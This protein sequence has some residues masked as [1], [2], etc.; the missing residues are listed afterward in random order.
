[1]TLKNGKNRVV[2]E[3]MGEEYIVR[4]TSSTEHVLEA[5][6]CVNRLLREYWGK[7]P[8][9]S[10]QKIAV[11]AAL[12]LASELLFLQKKANKGKGDR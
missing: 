2:L 8:R 11:L 6:R 4:S 12:N 9:I 5:G 1:M 3:I 7:Y 10:L